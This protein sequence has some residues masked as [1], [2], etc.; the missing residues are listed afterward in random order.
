[1]AHQH[2]MAYSEEEHLDNLLGRGAGDIDMIGYPDEPE[3]PDT[4][5]TGA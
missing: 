1:M 4:T 2:G 3:Q 5:D